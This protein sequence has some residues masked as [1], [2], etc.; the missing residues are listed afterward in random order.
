MS[1]GS[2]ID[3]NGVFLSKRLGGQCLCV[4]LFGGIG[5]LIA[6]A[7]L[8][9]QKEFTDSASG[10]FDSLLVLICSAIIFA[11]FLPLS[12]CIAC[13]RACW[14]QMQK[15]EGGKEL[16]MAEEKSTGKERW[17]AVDKYIGDL[18]IPPDPVL[19]ETL[20]TS[21]AA[22]LPSINVSPCQG[23][24]LHLLARMI[25]A[26][27]I[28]EIGTLGGYST[29]WLARALPGN[30]RLI[31]L[32]YEPKHAKVAAANFHRAGLAAM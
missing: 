2:R 26:K 1:K 4:A 32:E 24:F 17:T 10:P 18:L 28:L 13:Y 27:N 14:E 31:T 15:S 6:I 19:D 29:I 23:K 25:K 30:G 5:S 7:H 9:G 11:T 21:A 22:G 8:S 12:F 3:F 16:D 20:K